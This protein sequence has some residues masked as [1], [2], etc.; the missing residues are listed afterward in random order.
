MYKLKDIQPGMTVV[1]RNG[2][3]RVVVADGVLQIDPACGAKYAAGPQLHLDEYDNRL[4]HPIP[5]FDIT[6]VWDPYIGPLWQE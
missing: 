5:G 3:R 2:Q 1:L 6:A 4:Q